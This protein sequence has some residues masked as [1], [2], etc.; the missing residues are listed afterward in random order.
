MSNVL[1]EDLEEREDFF[2]AKVHAEL[3]N[4]KP[5]HVLDIIKGATGS[6]LF[7]LLTGVLYFAVWSISVSPK[8]LIEE[9][10]DVKITSTEK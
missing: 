6:L 4:I 5:N 1:S 10:F 3:A 2:T 9:I 7:I 8:I